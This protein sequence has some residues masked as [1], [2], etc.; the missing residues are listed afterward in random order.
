[1]SLDHRRTSYPKE[2]LTPIVMEVY[3]V[4]KRILVIYK[5]L[6]HLHYFVTFN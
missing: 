5:V 1:M 4:L 6:N 3:M 2:D